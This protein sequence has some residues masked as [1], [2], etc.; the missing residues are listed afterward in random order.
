M[1]MTQLYNF[2]K[3]TIVMKNL[4][5][6]TSSVTATVVT[7]N[8]E[9]LLD[10]FFIYKISV[11]IEKRDNWRKVHFP[12]DSKIELSEIIRFRFLGETT[13]GAR[14]SISKAWSYPER[15]FTSSAC[16]HAYTHMYASSLRERLASPQRREQID[17]DATRSLT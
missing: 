8:I 2:V 6:V 5:I 13:K 7:I 12:F 9:E 15:S 3:R 11:S 16:T 4:H 10:F 14:G 1:Q 17:L